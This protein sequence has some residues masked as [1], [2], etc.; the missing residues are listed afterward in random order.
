MT[1]DGRAR[2][3]DPFP[4]DVAWTNLT[5]AGTAGTIKYCRRNGIN[6]LWCSM[7][8]ATTNN[9]NT[10]L[11]TAGNGL[12]TAFRPSSV[13]TDTGIFSGFAATV[14][15]NT[16]GSITVFQNTGANRATVFFMKSWPVGS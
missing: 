11:V 6:F 4:G 16:D 9:A 1:W 7:T 13:I 15:I 14:N 8:I 12:P 10:T 5:H 2:A 3:T